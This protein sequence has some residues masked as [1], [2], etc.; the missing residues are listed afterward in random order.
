MLKKGLSLK[1]MEKIL[2]DSGSD[3]ISNS[4]KELLDRLSAVLKDVKNREIRVEGHTDNKPIGPNLIDKFPTN[5]DLSTSRA[6]Q[7]VK[8]LSKGGVDPN[9][10]S[11][12]GYSKYHPVSSNDTKEGREQNRRIEVI[13]Y[14]KELLGVE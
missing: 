7:V 6:S 8:Y 4:G 2:F 3:K 1:I 12:S 5:W 9:V 11:A 10:M 13:L 14:P